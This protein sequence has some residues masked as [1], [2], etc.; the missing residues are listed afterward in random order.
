M[1]PSKD[2]RHLPLPDFDPSIALVQAARRDFEREFLA[3]RR[4]LDQVLDQAKRDRAKY[5]AALLLCLVARL[6]SIFRTSA[7]DDRCSGSAPCRAKYGR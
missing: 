4:A 7:D 6:K 1:T 5:T 3:H 2:W